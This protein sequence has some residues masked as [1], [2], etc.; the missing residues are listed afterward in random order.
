MLTDVFSALNLYLCTSMEADKVT[1][2]LNLT[3]ASIN[4][5]MPST[6]TSINNNK[7]NHHN[8]NNAFSALH[9][10]ISI[11]TDNVSTAE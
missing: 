5:S 6:T 4:Y 8:N 3:K 11:K 2:T 1:L 7:D 9:L 10:C